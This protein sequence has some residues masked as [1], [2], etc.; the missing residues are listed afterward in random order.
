MGIIFK[1]NKTKKEQVSLRIW[2]NKNSHI[3]YWKSNGSVNVKKT[4]L[5]SLKLYNYHMTQKF[6]S[7]LYQKDLKT[8]TQINTCTF[9]FLTTL[10]KRTKR[11]KQSRYPS[12]PEWWTNCGISIQSNALQPT[13]KGRKCWCLLHSSGTSE[14]LCW[15][16]QIHIHVY[17]HMIPFIWNSQNR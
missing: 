16:N 4:L 1:R 5:V 7:Y 17:I 13:K 8:G 10:F 3:L 9:L 14:T 11:W 12:A 2:G 15:R 6:Y